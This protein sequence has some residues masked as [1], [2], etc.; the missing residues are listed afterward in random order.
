MIDLNQPLVFGIDISNYNTVDWQ[1]LKNGPI[2]Y[3]FIKS[4]EGK[5]PKTFASKAA[6]HA[7]GAQ[8]IGMPYTFYH[9]GRAD[10]AHGN[11]LK[12]A[13]D[14]ATFFWQRINDLGG[15]GKLSFPP[16]L[17]YEKGVKSGSSVSNKQWVDAFVDQFQKL[18]GVL[19]I[20]YS[21]AGDWRAYGL[22]DYSYPGDFWVARGLVN[23]TAYAKRSDVGIQWGFRPPR[24]G[25]IDPWP[26]INTT[27]WQ[28]S[29]KGQI[30][31][32]GIP[33]GTS[34]DVNVMTQKQFDSY[35]GGG[36]G[37]LFVAGVMG[38]AVYLLM[39]KR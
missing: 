4:S 36:V 3:V 1:T 18:S 38:A 21:S 12:K 17:D 16:I 9:F 11:A 30:P 10:L 5:G 28:Y 14:E 7:A 23:D 15:M 8:S 19:P 13:R 24:N 34:Q 20:L 27:V 31:G 35:V 22:K 33:G 32:T 25:I 26:N 29:W 37:Q 39:R 6:A 2:K